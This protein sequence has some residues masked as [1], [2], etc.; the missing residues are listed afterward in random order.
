[1]KIFES[2]DI[3]EKFINPVLTVGNYDGLHVGHRAIIAE[4]KSRARAINGTSMLMTFHPH[5]LTIVGVGEHLGLITPILLKK[6]LIEEAGVDVLIV[7]PF[8]EDFRKTSPESFVSDIL[9]GL[10]NIRGLVVGYDF[11]FGA[12]GRGDTKVLRDLSGRY[13]FFF[14]VVEAITLAGEK[15]GSNR[16]RRLILEGDVRKAAMLLGRPYAL[17]GRVARGDGRGKTIGFPTIN[18]LTEFELIPKGGVYVTKAEVD[19]RQYQSVTNVGYNPT[20][21]GKSLSIETHL[22]SISEDFYGKE[23]SLYFHDRVR[24]EV[25]FEAVDQLKERIGMDVEIARAYFGG[26]GR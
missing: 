12:G 18:L 4:V 19:G 1:M 17:E 6:R 13:D 16:I 10:L 21:D 9:V 3:A 22:L 7:V 2:L 15:I 24:D 23:V 25:K 20:F 11:R 26:A 5:P 8:T 14:D